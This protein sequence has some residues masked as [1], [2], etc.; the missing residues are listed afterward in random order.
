ML[1]MLSYLWHHRDRPPIGSGA[2]LKCWA[3]RG[4][5]LPNL[6]KQ[7][8]FHGRLCRQGGKIAPSVFFSDARMITGRLDK[9]VIG[10]H[11]FVGRAEL[12]VH[13]T[14]SIGAC[15]C[16]N[17]GARLLTAT[18]D[19]SSP[20]WATVAKPIIIED[21]VWIATNA[22]VLPGVTLGRGAVVGAGAVV[23]KDVPPL[24]IVAGNPA[25]LLDK[26]RVDG[27]EYRP[28]S[29]L[30]LFGAWRACAGTV[31][32]LNAQSAP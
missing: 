11:S 18:H 27:L 10:E 20:H 21:H 4:R 23:S 8:A 24:G 3:K 5:Q 25:A 28:T 1:S 6:L 2:W 31:S 26:C 29:L 17:D 12:A 15:V 9:L 14:L 16:I 13:D 32:P 19:V 30:A 22:I 7:G